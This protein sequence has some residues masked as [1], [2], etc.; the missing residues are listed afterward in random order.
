MFA[1]FPLMLNTNI[2]YVNLSLFPSAFPTEDIKNGIFSPSSNI[3]R[4]LKIF[5]KLD[6]KIDFLE[7]CQVKLP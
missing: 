3:F 2:P 1:F 4:F 6:L 7:K 5:L